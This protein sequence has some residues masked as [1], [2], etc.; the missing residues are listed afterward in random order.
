MDIAPFR[1]FLGGW[2]GLMQA[3][4]STEV[5]QLCTSIT[6]NCAHPSHLQILIASYTFL[7]VCLF[8]LSSFIPA[9]L[10]I[11]FQALK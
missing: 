9:F 2:G 10:F 6:F 3:L 11:S 4:A 1:D 8:L 5:I 7:G